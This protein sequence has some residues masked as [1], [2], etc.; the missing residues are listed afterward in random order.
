MPRKPPSRSSRQATAAL[1]PHA[2]IIQISGFQHPKA[3]YVLLALQ[4]G[5]VGDENLTIGLR[6]QRPRAAGGGE[7][8]KENPDTGSHNLIVERVDIEGHRFV[9][10]GRV[11]VVG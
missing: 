9:L 8:A 10:C 7:A 3:A 6:S 11:V 1:R 2:Y 5:P 4:V